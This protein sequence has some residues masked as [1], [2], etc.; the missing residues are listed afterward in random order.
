MSEIG[1]DAPMSETWR[2]VPGFEHAYEVSSEGQIRSKPR[3]FVASNGHPGQVKGTIL[4]PWRGSSGYLQVY[5]GRGNPKLVHHL[6]LLAFKGERGEGLEA[7]HL[8]GDQLDNSSHNL[9][10]ATHSVN[11][12][13]KQGHGTSWHRGKTECPM[14]HLLKHPNLVPGRAKK[15]HRV[16]Y[17]CS[18]ERWSAAGRLLFSPERAQERYIELMKGT[19]DE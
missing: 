15:G 7:R 12:L 5:L 19:E 18:L 9:E 3:R 8:N 17:A 13:D 2:D 14:G 16:C 11:E 10:W 6:V 4:K 1:G